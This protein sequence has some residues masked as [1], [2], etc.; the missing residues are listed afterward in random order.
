MPFLSMTNLSRYSLITLVLS[1]SRDTPWMRKKNHIIHSGT[2]SFSK[3]DKDISLLTP[4]ARPFILITSPFTQMRKRHWTI[5]ETL[6]QKMLL[7][8]NMFNH[9]FGGSNTGDK[10]IA[11][12]Q[13]D[14][15]SLERSH[16]SKSTIDYILLDR[17]TLI[18]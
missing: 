7:Q 14:F 1:S 13:K 5:S 3:H 8:L 9:S 15:L 18:Y 12:G 10:H 16:S 2:K 6:A 11:T 4:R 17:L